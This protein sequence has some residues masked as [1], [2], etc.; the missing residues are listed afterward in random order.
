MPPLFNPFQNAAVA[1]RA[2]RHHFNTPLIARAPSFAN[3]PIIIYLY[4]TKSLILLVNGALAN[5]LSQFLDERFL[6]NTR[7]GS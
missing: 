4:P 1:N 7:L 6:R 5:M 2:G 3:T